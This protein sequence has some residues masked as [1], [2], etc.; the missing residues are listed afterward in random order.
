MIKLELKDIT[1][2]YPSDKIALK[3]ININ[4]SKKEFISIIGPSGCGKTTLLRII[5]G[6][7]ESTNGE[8]RINS[9]NNSLNK[10][11]RDIAM[12]FQ[13]YGLYPQLSV[14]EN[15][16]IFLKLSGMDK[17]ER[18]KRVSLFSKKMGLENELTK[19][20][21][22][23]SGGQRQRVAIAK[24]LVRR[25]LLF[26]MDEP[27][28]NL[29]AK[30]RVEMRNLISEIYRDNEAC[31]IYVTH[32]QQEAMSL[33]SLIVVMNEGKIQQID[34]PKNIYNQPKNIFVANFIGEE[35]M[36][37]LEA[38]V[39]CNKVLILNRE[40]PIPQN[41]RKKLKKYDYITV[42]IRP[43]GFN[44][45]KLNNKFKAKIVQ[46]DIYGDSRLLTCELG[47]DRLL[48]RD[49]NIPYDKNDKLGNK[50]I[51]FNLSPDHLHFFD[52][53]TTERIKAE[54]V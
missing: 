26:L 39:C 20:P 33:S 17:K 34:T 3:D 13:D 19:R 49:Y 22:Q 51:K 52:P 12:V 25:P 50:E 40:I 7:E 37:L 44:V 46:E 53:F 10:K 42:G 30:L 45:C 29:D 48:I 31:F 32:D 43:E 4:I 11:N 8:V 35:P 38:K 41:L 28:S 54:E 21:S 6:L 47:K 5:A 1:K 9:T 14:E 15:I 2:V 36:N 18:K 27:L 23:L 24:A 16:E